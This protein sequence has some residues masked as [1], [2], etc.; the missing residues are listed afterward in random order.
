MAKIVR[1]LLI[2]SCDKTALYGT[3]LPGEQTQAA[4]FCHKIKSLFLFA[5][6]FLFQLKFDDLY[7]HL[8]LT[9]FKIYTI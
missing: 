9:I 2:Q 7:G 1:I 6:S 4:T 8:V 3:L 5:I